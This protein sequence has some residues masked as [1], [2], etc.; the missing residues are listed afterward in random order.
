VPVVV[1]DRLVSKDVTRTDVSKRNT[2]DDGE[3]A[4]PCYMFWTGYG[5][6]FRRTTQ[7][8][9]VYVVLFVLWIA[10]KVHARW[11]L[12]VTPFLRPCA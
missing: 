9:W 2:S 10:N 3:P 8:C 12:L 1:E 6:P 4:V 7:T 11:Y 5:T